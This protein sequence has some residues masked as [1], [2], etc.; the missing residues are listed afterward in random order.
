MQ[1]KSLLGV[2]SDYRFETSKDKKVSRYLKSYW[3]WLFNSLLIFLSLRVSFR[4]TGKTAGNKETCSRLEGNYSVIS[5]ENTSNYGSYDNTHNKV[6]LLFD[7]PNAMSYSGRTKR[8]ISPH[9]QE[10]D[11]FL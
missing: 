7:I 1:R 5:D 3:P 4:S 10:V 8:A 11:P 2:G 9:F 6:P